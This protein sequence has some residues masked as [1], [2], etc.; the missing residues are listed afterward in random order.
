MKVNV[1]LLNDLSSRPHVCAGETSPGQI[2]AAHHLLDFVKIPQCDADD[3]LRDI[4]ARVFIAVMEL[5]AAYIRL[6]RIGGFHSRE[7][8]AHGTVGDFCVECGERWPCETRRI[9]NGQDDVKEEM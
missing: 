5:N 7:T 8:G 9:V 4:D 2:R 1:Q 6:D 3:V